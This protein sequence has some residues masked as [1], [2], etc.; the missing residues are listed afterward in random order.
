LLLGPVKSGSELRITQL[1][2]GFTHRRRSEALQSARKCL[3]QFPSDVVCCRT[4][5]HNWFGRFEEQSRGGKS[6]TLPYHGDAFVA[7]AAWNTI[8]AADIA[9]REGRRI[10]VPVWGVSGECSALLLAA[11]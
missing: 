7:S 9:R 4:A 1:A 8:E 3:A 6:L 10:L 11:G 2:D 5:R